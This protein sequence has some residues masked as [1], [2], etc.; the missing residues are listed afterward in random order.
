MKWDGASNITTP[1]F[2]H[3]V[4]RLPNKKPMVSLRWSSSAVIMASNMKSIPR[5]VL[6]VVLSRF[7]ERTR[8]GVFGYAA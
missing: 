1:H 4:P 8:D 6:L 2:Y 3:L 5:C 7:S